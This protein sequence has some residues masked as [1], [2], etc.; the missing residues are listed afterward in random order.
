M[1]HFIEVTTWHGEPALVNVDYIIRIESSEEH[2]TIFLKEK[3]DMDYY[4]LDVRESYD[5]IKSLITRSQS[6]IFTDMN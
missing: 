5:K 4:G 3:D 1:R 6:F 2:T